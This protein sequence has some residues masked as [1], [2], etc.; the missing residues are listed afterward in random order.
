MT[1]VRIFSCFCF[2]ALFALGAG[3]PAL[4]PQPAPTLTPVSPIATAVLPVPTSLPTPLPPTPTIT[5]TPL[6]LAKGWG[7]RQEISLDGK[8]DAARVKV[9]S[10]D[11][12]L[13]TSGWQSF[14]VPGLLNGYNYERAWFRRKFT[15]PENW[16]GQKLF[17]H[18]GGVKFN[19]RVLINGKNVGGAFNGYDAFDVDI[20][21]AV[22][23]GTENELAV[24]VHD[25]TGVF[26]T[27]APVN[28]PQGL[29]S[30][31]LRGTPRDRILAPIGGYLTLYG[32]WDS[33]TLRVVPSVYIENIFARPLVSQ[34]RLEVDVTITN[35]GAQAFAG[36]LNA[37]IFKWDGAGR[38]DSG[39]WTLQGNAVANF[40]PSDVN[41]AAGKTMTTTLHLEKPPLE[42]WSPRSATPRLYVLEVGFSAGDAVRERIGYREFTTRNGD[43]YLN[44]KKVHLLATS[45]WPPTQEIDRE[46]VATE[47]QAIR[48]MNAVAFRTHTQPWR[49]LW[50]EVADEVGV[51][52]IPEGAVWN[53]DGVYRVDDAK[54][55]DNYAAHLRAMARTL[56]NH[57]SVVM[58]SLENEMFGSRANVGSRSESE[59]AQLGALVK[60]DDPTRPITYESDGDPGGATDVIGIHYP[61]EFPDKRLWPPDAYWLDTARALSGRMFWNSPTFLWTHQKPLYIGEYLWVP[62]D[63]PAVSTLFF[64]DDAYR[65]YKPYYLQAKALAWRM[66]MLAYRAF[67]VSGH[68]PWS[69]HDGPMDERNPTWVAHRD[70]YRP[71]AAFTRQMDSRFYTGQTITRTVELFNDTMSDLPQV[72]F[73]WTLL[74]SGVQVVDGGETLTM[75]SGDHQSREI[76]IALPNVAARQPFILRL[77]MNVGGDERF[78]DDLALEVFPR[79]KWSPPNAPLALFDPKGNFA[80]SLTQQGVAF[81]SL[82]QL[83][84]WDAQGVLVVGPDALTKTTTNI[85]VIGEARSEDWLTHQVA[86]GARVL[87]LEQSADAS[88]WLP[89]RLSHQSSTFAFPQIAAHPVL[90]GITAADLRWWRGDHIVSRDEP[91]RLPIGG[92]S[93]LVVTGNANGLA[94]APLVE[95]RE[96]RGVW[97]ISQLLIASKLDSE[98]M[99]RVLFE[100]M[101]NYLADQATQ[102]AAT[103][104]PSRPSSATLYIGAPLQDQ[105]ARFGVDAQPLA[106][107]NALPSSTARLLVLQTDGATIAQ[108]ADKIRAFA[109]AGGNVLWHR[110]DARDFAPARD[111]LKL[112]VTMQSFR[113][114]SPRAEGTSDFWQ[115]LTREDLYWLGLHEGVSWTETSLADDVADAVFLADEKVPTANTFDA[116]QNARLEG[117]LVRVEGNAITFATN[118]RATWTVQVPAA[119]TYQFGIF[120]RGSPVKD[121]YPIVSV[122]LDGQRVGTL[123]VARKESAYYSLPIR[124]TAGAHQIAIAFTNDA[125]AGSEDRNLYVERYALNATAS[126]DAATVEALTAP[127]SLVSAPIGKGRIVLNA[128]R[129]DDPGRNAARAQR[130]IA[131]LLTTLGATSHSRAQVSIIEAEEMTPM[132]NYRYFTRQFDSVAMITNGYIETQMRVA[133]A[134]K[135]RI[136]VA[137]RGTPAA[138]VYPM[139]A[140]ELNG[141]AVGQVECK[142]DAFSLHYIVAELPA[143]TFNLR[144]RYTNDLQLQDKGEDRNLYLDRIEFELVP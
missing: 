63:S 44:G 29:G 31:A 73:R 53:D 133:T 92:A 100:R 129:W 119:G 7:T 130:F 105:L 107:W 34:N 57:P 137:A 144:V 4:T 99:A 104:A 43:F 13:P 101:V 83:Q 103:T 64:G 50:Y 60:R 113:G 102:V 40:A 81:R 128:I 32:I 42:T 71:L 65:D 20:S 48:A 58:W 80:N 14:N 112:P 123:Y 111:A 114:P 82:K 117:T 115:A 121:V 142:S 68:S 125:R 106:D 11:D 89:V 75:P 90:R 56:R 59:L 26:S 10:L 85:P 132:P 41:I 25:W 5:P 62:A 55:W 15:A 22:R 95:V 108:N 70:L 66:Q 49:R 77:T 47:L 109:N 76:K 139:V 30:D 21:D 131:S 122:Y 12:P 6:P 23:F 134:G 36:A 98:P 39:Q 2:V 17:L 52:M 54:F 91:Y 87:V 136:G 78:R 126:R 79:E 84:D 110:P 1:I 33:V 116:R 97:L 18:F 45:Y 69:V 118:G 38:D 127:A 61:N 124:A 51:M 94:N 143:G 24:G 19:S 96:G 86:Q 141:K 37:R 74:D 72:A 93:P 8:L 88:A 46:Y 28:F 27:G 120:A 3:V 135:Y 138:G 35:A 16:R 9:K 67:D 140:L